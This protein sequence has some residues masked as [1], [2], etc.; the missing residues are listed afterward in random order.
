MIRILIADDHPLIRTGLKNVLEKM[1]EE[2]LIIAEA[3]NGE[4]ALNKI[5]LYKPDMVFIDF[6]MPGK[7]GI[8][9]VEKVLKS[10]PDTIFI[11]LTIHNNP[12]YLKEATRVG[13]S[14]Y[15]LKEF[16][17]DEL[18]DC[19]KVLKNGGK[20]LSRYMNSLDN[21]YK[22]VLTRREKEILKGIL[23]G[24][25]NHELAKKLFCG[26][27][28]VERLKTNLRK[29]LDLPPSRNSLIFWAIKNE[30]LL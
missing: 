12:H 28:N 5:L 23:K 17:L 13:V 22:E 24:D 14:G 8:E 3:N 19:V 11:M 6:S 29:K 27:K 7:D 16:A 30:K 10:L 25:D 20:Y 26:I 9:V 21:V 15:L 4:A 2:Y 18:E 1:S